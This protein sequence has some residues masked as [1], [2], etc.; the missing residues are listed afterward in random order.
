MQWGVTTLG[1]K[2]VSKYYELTQANPHLVNDHPNLVMFP[3]IHHTNVSGEV[4]VPVCL[5]NLDGSP[6]K[7]KDTRTIG[8]MKEE[9][10]EE[11]TVTTQTAYSNP[12][13]K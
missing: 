8:L 13:V 9:K 3:T 7:I 6:V 1:E 12:F 2:S 10:I 4:E 11:G 5:I